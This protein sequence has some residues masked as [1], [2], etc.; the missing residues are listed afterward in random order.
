MKWLPRPSLR[1]AA[2]LAAAVA[3]YVAGQRPRTRN[4]GFPQRV[5]MALR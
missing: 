3:L 5:R 2:L 4:L 1:T